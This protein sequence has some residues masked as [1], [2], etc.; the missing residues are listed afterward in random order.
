MRDAEGNLYGTAIRGGTSN[1]GVVFKV[2]SAGHQTVLHN[3]TG[4]S[5]GAP[6]TASLIRDSA[7]NLYGTAQYGGIATGTSGF[8]TVYKLDSLGTE[9][10]LYTFKGS[11]DGGS[12]YAGVLRDAAGNL[13]GTTALGGAS[14]Y[15]VV[16][17]LDT[18][19][20][21]TALYAFTGGR[22][23]AY[24]EAN[25][26]R[27]PQGNIYGT[28]IKGGSAG[29]GV[30]FKLDADGRE[31]VLH[32]FTG[33]EDGATPTSNLI[34]DT[35]GNLSAPPSPADITPGCPASASC[36]SWMHPE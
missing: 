19:G 10:V 2:D 34:R 33:G 11:V 9:T 7:G 14:N 1:Y 13:Y 6:P 18:T 3:F 12:P 4:G 15:G 22:D 20:N 36:L 27:D 24:P 30:A 8:G 25:L 5:D 29:Y 16:F 32:S 31:T 35:K 23:G 21:E 28:A 26:T 17:K